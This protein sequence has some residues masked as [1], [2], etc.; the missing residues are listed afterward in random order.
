M[1]DSFNVKEIEKRCEEFFSL[2]DHTRDSIRE[3]CELKKIHSREVAKNSVLIAEGM[4]LGRYDADMA[5]VIGELHDFARF[6]QA[7]TTH[8]LDDSDKFMH[9]HLGAHILF[10]HHLVDDIIP[11]YDKISDEDKTVME[12]AVYHHS[13]Y[14]IPDDLTRRENLFCRIIRQADQLDI[15]RVM[16]ETDWKVAYGCTREE[17]L[18]TGI[19]KP[20]EDAFYAHKMADYSKRV[21]TADFHMAHIA[22]IFGLE[23]RPARRMALDQGHISK[24]MD[25]VFSDPDVQK[26]FEGMRGEVEVFLKS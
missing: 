1:S 24:M 12:K 23:S 15:F 2:Y 18:K 19:S 3:M 22:I 13:D 21:T 17:L 20:I 11:D 6:G 14:H 16:A 25:I 8:S 26:R 4:G 7:V 10:T 5:W 9:A